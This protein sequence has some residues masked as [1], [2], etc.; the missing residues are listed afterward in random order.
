MFSRF[1]G[2]FRAIFLA[3]LICITVITG[4][5]TVPHLF[6]SPASHANA[7]ATATSTVVATGTATTTSGPPVHLYRW[8]SPDTWQ[9]KPPVAGSAVTIPANRT[10]LLDTSPPALKSLTIQGTLICAEQ[11]LALSA[12]WIM[13]ESSGALQCGTE[14]QPFQ[15]QFVITLTGNNTNEDIMQMGTKLLGVSGGRLDLH[16]QPTVSWIHLG[17]TAYAGTSQLVLSQTVNWSAGQHLALASTDYSPQ[18]AEEVVIKSI[19]GTHVTLK[20]P[21]QYTH[22][23][24]LQTL[25]GQSVDERAEIGLITHNIVVQG[26]S[27]S[28]QTGFGGQSMFMRNSLVRIA[29]VEFYHMGQMQRLARYPVHWH[30]AGDATGDYIQD[31]SIAHSFNRCI[32]IHGTNDLLVRENVTFD[33]IGHCYFMEDG[34][35]T[36]NLLEYNLGIATLKPADGQNLLPSD[37]RP[38]TFWIT[39]PDNYFIGNVAAGSPSQGFWFAL[40]EHPTGLES[41]RTDIWPR[42]TPLG[43]FTDNV[44]HSNG[45][46]GLF[47]DDGPNANGTLDDY[48]YQPVKKPGNTSSAPVSAIFQNFTGYKQGFLAVWIRGYYLHLSGATLADNGDGAICACDQGFIENSLMIGESA[49]KG[50]PSPGDPHGLD[51]RSLPQPWDASMPING[52]SFYDGLV[53]VKNVTFVNFVSNSQRPAGGLSYRRDN[54]SPIDQL[55]YA[56]G[57]RAIN[58]NIVYLAKPTQ[59]GDRADAFLDVDGSVTGHAGMYVVANNP[60]LADSGCSFQQA[61]N[62][63]ACQHHYDDISIDSEGGQSIAPVTV[64]RSDG[65]SEQQSGQDPDYVSVS[66]LPGYTYTWKFPQPATSLQIDYQHLRSGDQVELAFSY[67]SASCK[68]YR[69][70]EQDSPIKAASSLSAFNASSGNL[71]YYDATSGMLSIKL[72]PQHGNDWA[73]VNVEPA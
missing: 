12:N 11:N 8:S 45:E 56:Q 21:L 6:A 67:P 35:E 24:Q 69:D 7:S 17:Q 46:I 51:G 52:F 13:V 58:A 39:N 5:I 37:V 64:T 32:T 63:Y 43:L 20:S 73:R 34:T 10:V 26:D 19:S 61:W 65:V 36:H 62:S 53:A 55:N 44:A 70:A 33:T 59:D 54:D 72:I 66:A 18:Q 42:Q 30:L 16:G 31:S 23:G 57:I 71:Y 48:Y 41:N 40:P 9:G 14:L 60:I 27:S 15:H 68:L 1:Q 47:V 2:R 49:N 22:Y 50:T 29:D 4:I 3:V 38:A 25:G 28:T